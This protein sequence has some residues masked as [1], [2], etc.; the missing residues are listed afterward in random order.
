MSLPKI[1]DTYDSPAGLWYMH[2][3]VAIMATVLICETGKRV[4]GNG[5]MLQIAHLHTADL[6]KRIPYW[7]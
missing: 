4:R 2:V 1:A 7:F 5:L 3:G 6:V